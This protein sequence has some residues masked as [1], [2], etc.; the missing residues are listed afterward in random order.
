MEL[1]WQRPPGLLGSLGNAACLLPPPV[2]TDVLVLGAGVVGVAT[3]EALVRRGLSVTLV[4]R[5]TGPGQ[6]ASFA[7]G[8]QLSYSYTD[9]L[10]SP[11][12][13]KRL[14]GILAA[15]DPAFRVALRFDPAYLR[16]CLA[17]FA[18]G[19]A[20]RFAANSLEGLAIA[21]R[22]RALMEELLARHPIDFAHR[23]PGK[24]LLHEDAA[25]FRAAVA[26]ADAKRAGGWRC[27]R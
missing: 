15:T 1:G 17:F 9:A 7:N 10:A 19:S 11:S 12:L 6:G 24:L 8:G 27:A 13:L 26:H 22:S 23:V 18:H 20:G 14:P 2:T 3:A 21:L 25:G 5:A 4:D 16:W